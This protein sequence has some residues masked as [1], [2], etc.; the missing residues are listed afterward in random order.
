[1]EQKY[2]FQFCPRCGRQNSAARKQMFFHCKNCDFCLYF[3][4]ATAVA[5]FVIRNDGRLLFI[6]RA[7]D[8]AKGKLSVPGGF[9]DSNESAEEALRREMREEVN[10]RISKIEYLCSFPNRYNYKGITYR[11]VDIFYFVRSI[12]GKAFAKEEVESIFWLKPEQVKPAQ[13]AFPSV[14]KAWKCWLKQIHQTN[15]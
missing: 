5:G 4:T 8:P 15:I 1:M 3:N 9:V 13:L 14:R 7:K 11:T 2:S 12:S 10:I 6:Q